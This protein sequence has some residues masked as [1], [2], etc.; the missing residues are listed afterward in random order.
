MSIAFFVLI[1]PRQ[2][3]AILLAVTYLTLYYA[4]TMIDNDVILFMSLSFC[5]SA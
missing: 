4:I 2:T 1:K 3:F 5:I